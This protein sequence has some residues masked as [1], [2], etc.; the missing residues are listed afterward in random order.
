MLLSMYLSYRLANR[1]KDIHILLIGFFVLLVS[2]CSAL[3]PIYNEAM[4]FFFMPV[5]VLSFPFY[6]FVESLFFEG[7]EWVPFVKIRFFTLDL[8]TLLPVSRGQQ[9]AFP[10]YLLVNTVG[11]LLGYWVGRKYRIQFLLSN[12]EWLVLQLFVA[13]GSIGYAFIVDGTSW[14]CQQIGFNLFLFGFFMIDTL[15]L[16]LLLSNYSVQKTNH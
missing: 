4:A 15:L 16:S 13:I 9:V 2:F 6:G 11:A 12:V 8:T 1:G 7:L 5:S 3:L 14:F 10:L